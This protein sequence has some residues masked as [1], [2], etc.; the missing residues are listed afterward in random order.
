MVST[1]VI[2]TFG[3]TVARE[4]FALS[5]QRD[6]AHLAHVAINHHVSDITHVISIS[7]RIYAYDSENSSLQRTPV[8]NNQ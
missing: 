1:T 6:T 7:I 3:A 2:C 4:S 8:K 5:W